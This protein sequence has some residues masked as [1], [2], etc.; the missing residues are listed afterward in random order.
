MYESRDSRTVSQSLIHLTRVSLDT[1]AVLSKR[2]ILL[3]ALLPPANELRTLN[4]AIFLTLILLSAFVYVSGDVLQPKECQEVSSSVTITSTRL[5]LDQVTVTITSMSLH[6]RYVTL[7]TTQCLP[8]TVTQKA[9]VTIFAE[10]QVSPTTEYVT[11]LQI[12]EKLQV[13][14]S[15]VYVPKLI[16]SIHSASHVDRVYESVKVTDTSTSHSIVTLLTTVTRSSTKVLTTTLVDVI[17]SLTYVP[18]YVSE[19]QTNA[20]PVYQTVYQKEYV[21]H[22]S[23]LVK[24][25]TTLS[26]V[27][28]CSFGYMQRIFG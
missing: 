25:V 19:T 11:D 14:T 27:N 24:T 18:L 28:H 9:L 3:L 1:L 8:S 17:S 2:H 7:T 21:K 6:P 15:T 23:H 12:N 26:T 5:R 20:F 22:T 10:Q 16:T 13:Y 4:M